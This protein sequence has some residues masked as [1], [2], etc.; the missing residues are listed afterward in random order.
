MNQLLFL[1]V[2]KFSNSDLRWVEAE[3]LRGF[4]ADRTA[5]AKNGNRSIFFLTSC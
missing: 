4:N 1:I 2:R 3:S 5:H